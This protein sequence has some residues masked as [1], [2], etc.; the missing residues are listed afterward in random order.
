MGERPL[1]IPAGSVES[2]G[3]EL[4]ACLLGADFSALSITPSRADEAPGAVRAAMSRFAPWD[5]ERGID[6]APR[7]VADLGDAGAARL[8][9]PEARP[10]IEALA[11]RAWSHGAPVIG[12]GGDHSVTW[13]LLA[14]AAAAAPQARIGVVQLDVHHDVRDPSAGVTNGTPIRGL[15]EEGVIAAG[16]VVQI[17]IHP[18]GN[19]RALT[20]WCDEHGVHRI[21]LAELAGYGPTRAAGEAL[22]LLAECD[23]VY[24][25]VDIDV[26]DRAFAPGTGAALP[27]GVTPGVLGELVRVVC[28]DPRVAAVDVVEFDPTRDVAA[29]TAYN[30]ALVVLQA[31]TA[32]AAR[33]ESSGSGA[34]R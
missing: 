31:L 8:A 23:L 22:Q 20:E 15:V 5:A 10:A 34:R 6:L 18:F 1:L 16:D 14:A 27:G 24:L 21:S 3:R 17:G 30:A 7:Y 19:R 12:L 29:V 9:W 33:G 32:F 4:L 28:A 11:A 25:T 13:P 26:L 2:D